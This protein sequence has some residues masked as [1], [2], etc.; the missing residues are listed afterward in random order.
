[1]SDRDALQDRKRG[2]EEEYFRKQEKALIEKLKQQIAQE[3]ERKQRFRHSSPEELDETE[4]VA[5]GISHKSENH[6]LTIES[7]RGRPRSSCSHR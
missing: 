7:S 6:V 5:E 1:M 3:R 4:P 2:L